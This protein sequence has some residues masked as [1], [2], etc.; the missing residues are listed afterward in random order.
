MGGICFIEPPMEQIMFSDAAVTFIRTVPGEGPTLGSLLE[1][2]AV[3]SF[4]NFAANL[5]KP[6]CDAD[7][8]FTCRRGLNETGIVFISDETKCRSASLMV[9]AGA[10][11]SRDMFH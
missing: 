11:V 8:N 10:E 6:A 3:C 7:A 1:K 9:V 5:E 2:D 4:R